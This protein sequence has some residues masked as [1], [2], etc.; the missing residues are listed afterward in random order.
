MLQ[1]A[2]ANILETN[3]KTKSLGK[4]IGDIKMNQMEIFE[5]KHTITEK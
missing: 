3:E 1:W 5:P 4:K 2:I